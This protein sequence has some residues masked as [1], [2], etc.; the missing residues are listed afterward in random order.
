MFTTR[1]LAQESIDELIEDTQDA[2]KRG[3]IIVDLTHDYFRIV[4]VDDD[5]KMKLPD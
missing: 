4:E 2:F 5:Y 3:D 1:E